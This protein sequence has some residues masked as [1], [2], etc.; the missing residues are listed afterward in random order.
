LPDFKAAKFGTAHASSATGRIRCGE[1]ENGWRRRNYPLLFNRKIRGLSIMWLSSS[2]HPLDVPV[3]LRQA[4]RD[5]QI[6]EFA[7]KSR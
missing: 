6:F 7:I 1:R 3:F 2:P 4:G 5:S